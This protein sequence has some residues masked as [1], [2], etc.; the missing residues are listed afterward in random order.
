MNTQVG[1]SIGIALLMAAG[2]LAALFAMGVFS[3]TGVGAQ[4]GTTPAKLTHLIVNDAGEGAITP[5]FSPDTHEYKINLPRDAGPYLTVDQVAVSGTTAVVVPGDSP[6]AALEGHQVALWGDTLVKEIKITVSDNDATNN[7]TEATNFAAATYT[8]MLDYTT[9]AS[10]SSAGAAV[11]VNLETTNLK[12]G[13]N[14]DLIIEFA[15]GFG[16]P[17][18]IDDDDVIINS[19]TGNQTPGIAVS[20]NNVTLTV[21]DMD[22]P[23]VA[24]SDDNIETSDTVLI[25]FKQSAGI[26]N[27]AIAGMHRIK[28]KDGSGVVGHNVVK[29]IRSI[30]I[31]PKNGSSKDDVTV[32]GKGFSTGS[33]TVFIDVTKDSDATM[34]GN[35]MSY[36]AD[37]KYE[38]GVDIVISEGA[39]ITDG[40]FTATIAGITKPD[41]LD[42]VDKVT[43]S[44]FDGSNLFAEETAEYTFASGLS[45][46]PESVSWG[47]TLTLTISDNSKVP[48][49]VRFGGSNSYKEKVEDGASAKEAKVVVPVG[50]PVGKQKV[51]ILTTAG[52][53][54]G[55]STTVE[56]VPLSLNVSPST[57]VPKQ[58]VTVN[59]GGFEARDHV[60]DMIEIGG[61]TV[62]VGT[63]RVTTSGR[64]QITVEVPIDVGTGKKKVKVTAGSRIGQVEIMV[65]SPSI[66][67]SPANSPAGST[68]RV[69]GTG[70]AAGERVEVL[71]DEEIEDV[72]KASSNGDVDIDLVVPSD[73]GIGATNKVKVQVRSLE[74]INKSAD[75]MTPGTDITVS[76]AEVQEG[77]KITISGTNFRARST[78]QKVTIGGESVINAPAP[79][80]LRDGSIEFVADVPFVGT[81]T[82]TVV[83]ED[84]AQNTA[85]VSLT[86]TDEPAA[87]VIT[88]PAELF[89]PLGDRLVRVWYL[90]RS[91][92]VWSFYDPDP[93]VAAFNT[94]TEVSSGQNVSIIIS[95]GESVEFQGMPLPLYQGTNPIALK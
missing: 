76:P 28:I 74:T 6:A 57:V 34:D 49:E 47:E 59:G 79:V 29:V 40:S 41:D 84:G 20:G 19:E 44:A 10:S 11:A 36:K 37:T 73:A 35:Q 48:T 63:N 68:I 38:S 67:V 69:T 62:P 1:K 71:Y 33:A 42:D 22:G 85:S 70:F 23:G 77:G 25:K 31:D 61:K 7:T 90:E 12:A 60:I 46:S 50:V 91:T 55:V 86:I 51:E 89:A 53:V 2:L 27:P 82:H 24:A 56:I 32:T 8:V 75:H 66:T 58:Q 43:I 14:E 92:Q 95:S 45:V 87:P 39:D 17:A 16:V 83:V 3:A 9:P 65:A 21:P 26:T 13:E 30:S 18:S 81:G 64:I 15:T 54:P 4:I 72:G 88:D 94:L 5:T 80:A 52:L 78:I 93:D